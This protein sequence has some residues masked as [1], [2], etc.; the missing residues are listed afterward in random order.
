M[1]H[2][3]IE[4]F[5]TVILQF[6]Q[7]IHNPVITPIFKAITFLGEAGLIW[8]CLGLLLTIRKKTRIIGITVLLSLIFCLIFGNGLL[9]H[10]VARPRPCWRNPDMEMLI[11]IPKDYS[12]PSGHTMSSFAAAFSVFVWKRSWGIGAVVLAAIMAVTRLYFYV[13]YPT[14]ILAGCL[15]GILLAFAAKYLVVRKMGK[16][17]MA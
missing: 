15:F 11:A 7:N 14:D 5:D 12:F 10:L 1:G 2:S 6:F 16:G 8:I 9:K 17:E 4:I 13:H 3:M